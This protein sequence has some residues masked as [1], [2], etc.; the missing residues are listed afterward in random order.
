MK[1]LKLICAAAAVAVLAGC[2]SIGQTVLKAGT[3]G[4]VRF[5]AEDVDKAI[6][7]AQKAGDAAGEACFRAIRKHVDV[8]FKVEPIGPV[9]SYAA[10]RVKVREARAGLA[11][12]VQQA[13]AVLVVDAG[14]FTSRFGLTFGAVSP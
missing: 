13:C 8:E 6:E 7:I 11:P 4:E 9:S 2:A 5:K 10:T 12:E 3:T 1:R 14:T